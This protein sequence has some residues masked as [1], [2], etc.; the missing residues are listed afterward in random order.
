MWI[1]SGQVASARLTVPTWAGQ[2]DR[3]GAGQSERQRRLRAEREV[4]PRLDR[5][6]C[7][8][9][10]AADVVIAL[11]Q[12]VDEWEP[13]PKSRATRLRRYAQIYER[14][15]PMLYLSQ[16]RR[17]IEVPDN[18]TSLVRPERSAPK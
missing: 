7:L 11:E 3:A 1:A 15:L 8:I 14:Q 10:Y 16:G 4:R 9:R 6:A 13:G 2:A 12:E 18:K 5:K 17:P